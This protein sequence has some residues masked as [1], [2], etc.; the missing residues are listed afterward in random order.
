MTKPK[1]DRTSEATIVRQSSRTRRGPAGGT[2]YGRPTLDTDPAEVLLTEIRRTAG[3][4]EWLADNLQN[5][6]PE[7]F[8]R[9]LWL[10][11][12]QSGFIKEEEIDTT[13]LSQA[14]AMWLELYMTER[15]HLATICRTALAAG[16]EER[17]VRLAERQAERVGEAFRGVLFD[18]AE[19]YGIEIDPEDE[20]VRSIVFKW[21]MQASG[22][23]PESEVRRT[24]M[25]LEIEP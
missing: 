22:A 23:T 4:I 1:A 11:K 2:L 9:G 19:L 10:A 5:S 14:G 25:R 15:R 3:H 7:K 16:I 20:A 8:V 12:R 18:L 17:R 21:L 6:D 13:D 24:T